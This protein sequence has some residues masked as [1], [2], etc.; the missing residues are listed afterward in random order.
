MPQG[1]DATPVRSLGTVTPASDAAHA[2]QIAVGVLAAAAL[3]AAMVF[4]ALRQRRRAALH[5]RYNRMRV[6]RG[7]PP[8]TPKQIDFIGRRR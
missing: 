1:R 4:R 6:D 7:M 2:W 8:L 3:A 5:A